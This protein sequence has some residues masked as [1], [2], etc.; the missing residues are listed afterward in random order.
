MLNFFVKFSEMNVACRRDY[1]ESV[2]LRVPGNSRLPEN[3][4]RNRLDNVLKCKVH[5][6]HEIYLSKC[7][8]SVCLFIWQATSLL[9]LLI[10]N[11]DINPLFSENS[12]ECTR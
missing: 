2:L 10:L 3:G 8:Q 4:F 6:T 12:W 7:L 9:I 11:T 5:T 1:S